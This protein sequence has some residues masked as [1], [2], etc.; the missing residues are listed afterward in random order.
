M[1]KIEELAVELALLDR[2]KV[3]NHQG[4]YPH[5]VVLYLNQ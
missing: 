3:L 1:N 4:L 2:T 5:C